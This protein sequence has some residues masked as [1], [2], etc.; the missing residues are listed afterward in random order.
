MYDVSGRLVKTLVDEPCSPGYHSAVWDGRD[1]NGNL[2]PSGIYFFR[3]T[4]EEHTSTR[5]TCLM[6]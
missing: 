2:V 6:R 5:K 1:R 3:L 4:A